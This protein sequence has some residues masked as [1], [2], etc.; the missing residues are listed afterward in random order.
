VFLC[1]PFY[2]ATLQYCTGTGI[3]S[4]GHTVIPAYRYYSSIILCSGTSTGT[5]VDSPVLVC[6]PHGAMVSLIRCYMIG[7]PRA[8]FPKEPRLC[9]TQSAA[10]NHP[11]L[12]QS[13]V[14]VS[15]NS[16]LFPSSP[17]PLSPLT[18]PLL[19]LFFDLER[20]SLVARHPRISYTLLTLRNLSKL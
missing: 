1:L 3:V 15:P 18:I 8:R 13:L 17:P 11:G 9:D 20:S 6:L 16:S 19:I 5:A 10:A 4:T 2:S 12:L 7:W 14:L